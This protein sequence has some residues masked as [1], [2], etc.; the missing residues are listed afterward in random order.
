MNKPSTQL[1]TLL[2][3]VLAVLPAGTT[4]AK[5]A[6]ASETPTFRIASYNINY[7]NPNLR[8]VVAAIRQADADVVALQETNRASERYLRRHLRKLY[9]HSRFEHRPRAGGFAFLSK[10]PLR[11]VRYLPRSKGWY[12]TYVATVNLAGRDIQL[13]NV[14]LK[15]TVPREGE[16]MVAF[17][18]RW[19]REGG[20]RRAEA[21]H[22]LETLGGK[23]PLVLLGDFNSLPSSSVA[24]YV[25]RRRLTDSY[26]TATPPDKR[27]HT[28][29]WKVNGIDW[30]FRLDYIYHAAA[31][32]TRTCRIIRG[33]GSDHDLLVSTLA[34]APAHVAGTDADTAADTRPSVTDTPDTPAKSEPPTTTPPAPKEL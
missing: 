8:G 24:T 5:E 20:I 17:L 2:L 31:M 9:P 29:H 25:K 15:P 7:G 18:A 32:V 3:T 10:V 34:W 27:E 16:E 21:V 4:C 23:T 1:L 22:I 33:K 12:G 19:T 13:V 28:W 11:N 6:V 14:H 30:S 26:E